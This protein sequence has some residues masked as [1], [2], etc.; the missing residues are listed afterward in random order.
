MDDYT[1]GLWLVRLVFQRGLAVLYLLAFAG[2]LNQFPALL[3]EGGLLPVANFIKRRSFIEGPSLFYWRCSDRFIKSVAW[4]GI[5]LSLL[6]LSGISESGSIVL[7]A[8][9]WL[10]LWFLYLSFLN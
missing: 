7:S 5:F 1:Q 10:G 2:A 9:T 6:A 3:G 4:V 8:A